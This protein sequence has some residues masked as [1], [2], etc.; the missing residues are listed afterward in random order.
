MKL[1][2]AQIKATLRERFGYLTEDKADDLLAYIKGGPKPEWMDDEREV[3]DPPEVPDRKP[4]ADETMPMDMDVEAGPTEENSLVDQISALV[5]GLEP[6]EVADLF[7]A[8]FE[9]VPGVEL[10]PAE[11]EPETLYTP[12]AEGRSSITLGPVRELQ[13]DMETLR[14]IVMEEAAALEGEE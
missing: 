10:G 7:Q 14:R 13:L 2:N 6:E 1:D 9:K 5:Q 3:P 8:V 4:G 11:E 12:G